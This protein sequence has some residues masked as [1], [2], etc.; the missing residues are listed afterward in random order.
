MK[1]QKISTLV[2][3]LGNARGGE[4]TWHSMYKNVLNPLNADLALLFW[5][6][7]NKSS[8]LY[9]KAD[10]IWEIEEYTDWGDYYKKRCRT[11]NWFTLAKKFST[12]GIMGGLKVLEN[13]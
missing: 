11:D 9:T 6:S 12:T 13:R 3:L 7:S 10:Y 5:Y 1:Y 8:S 2:V 4:K